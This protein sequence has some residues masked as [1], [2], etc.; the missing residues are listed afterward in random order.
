MYAEYCITCQKGLIAGAA[1][2]LAKSK[3]F[4]TY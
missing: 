4:K 2:R 1:E 3:C